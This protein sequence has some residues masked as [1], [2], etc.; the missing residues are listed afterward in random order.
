MPRIPF[1]FDGGLDQAHHG[2]GFAAEPTMQPDDG[3]TAKRV[4]RD[5]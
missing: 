1:S 5:V 2:E 4:S 3:L